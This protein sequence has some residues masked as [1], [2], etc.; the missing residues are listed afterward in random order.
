MLVSP[1][2]YL[3]TTPLVDV[4]TILA[5]DMTTFQQLPGSDAS[6]NKTMLDVTREKNNNPNF[7]KICFL[8]QH[9]FKKWEM[10][11]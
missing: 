1:I 9:H 8:Q 2:P 7:F 4:C 10:Y 6:T 11:G 3:D 5:Y